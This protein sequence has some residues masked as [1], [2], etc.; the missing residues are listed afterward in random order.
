MDNTE[1][2]KAESRV[3]DYANDM[4]GFYDKLAFKHIISKIDHGDVLDVGCGPIALYWTMGYIDKIDSLSFGDI[5]EEYLDTLENEISE[6][7]PETL[8]EKYSNVFDF[9]KTAGLSSSNLEE[10]AAHILTK[11]SGTNK[12]NFINE[13][14]DEEFDFILSCEALNVVHKK[15]DL[16]AAVKNC[17]E[18]LKPKGKLLGYFTRRA[19]DDESSRKLAELNLSSLFNSDI[20]DVESAINNA[21]LKIIYLE[22]KVNPELEKYPEAIYFIAE[23][24][25]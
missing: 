13:K 4:P 6:I 8:N 23:K 24:T 22:K 2:I 15:E 25:E 14:I 16:I 1:Q 5:S 9:V 10:I 19:K 3:F 18:M 20:E 17:S 7:S 21:G 12:L 11:F